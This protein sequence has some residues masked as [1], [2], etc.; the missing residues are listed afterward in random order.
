MGVR[1]Y[2]IAKAA[3]VSTATVSRVLNNP[4]LVREATRS[5]IQ[6][7]IEALAYRPNPFARGLMKAATDTVGVLVPYMTNP[8]F[9]AIVEAMEEALAGGGVR[10]YLSA[11]GESAERERLYVKEMARR[12]VD[13]L[14]LVE[15][16]SVNADSSWISSV[17]PSIPT[18]LV[19]E[20]RNLDTPFHVVRCVQ[21][22]GFLA[23]LD[24]LLAAD[25]VP[26]DL[27]L[28]ERLWSFELKERAFRDRLRARGLSPSGGRVV[29]V[30]GANAEVVVQRCAAYARE[31]LARAVPPGSFFAGNDLMGAGILQG[32]LAAGLRVPDDVSVVGVDNALPSRLSVPPLSTVD[33]R[34]KEIGR[35]V[36]DLYYSLKEGSEEV[37][38]VRRSLDSVYLDRGSA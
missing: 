31:S 17:A 24:N 4:G 6:A 38:P 26:V 11:T 22:P 1:I 18:I 21:E 20:H 28:G 34:E 2:D 13:A 36:A 35:T 25:R 3:G 32:V 37:L 16:P 15:T 27:V 29:R 30:P 19:N 8:Y 9:M 12:G 10:M 7:T 5:R 14:V 23:A 33:L